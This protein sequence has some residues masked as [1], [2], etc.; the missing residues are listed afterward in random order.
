M[1]YRNFSI[2]KG[3]GKLYLK[4]KQP[5]EGYE[6]ITYGE[7]KKTYHQYHRS[8]EGTPLRFG[9]K[10]ITYEGRT[11]RFLEFTLSDG[12]VEN[13]V[14]MNL[15]NKNGY[16]DESKALMSALRGIDL[17]ERVSLSP[18]VS[19]TTAKNGKEYENLNIYINYL[20]RDKTSDSKSPTTGY[21]HY[22]DI[23]SPTSKVVAGDKVWDWTPQTE[24][25]YTV[26]NEI[27]AKF[28]SGGS[29]TKTETPKAKEP[30]GAAKEEVN[31]DLPF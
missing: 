8:I 22:N 30:V 6:E 11:L 26:Q 24:F 20:D 4:A 5:T 21:I 23:P 25:Y 15:K 31:D 17:G 14:S 2:S 28:N 13:T 12:D 9:V 18:T 16:S 1:E 19:K 29:Q 27:T 7:G 3:K 10:E